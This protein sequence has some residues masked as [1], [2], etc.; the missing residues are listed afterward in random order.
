ML[1][2]SASERVDSRIFT[3]DAYAVHK[4][5]QNRHLAF[6]INRTVRPFKGG[7]ETPRPR[8]FP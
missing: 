5:H 6:R 1:G 8:V 7:E 2:S 4:N 3:T